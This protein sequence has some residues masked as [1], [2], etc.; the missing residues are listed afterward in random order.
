MYSSDS[1]MTQKVFFTNV[2]EAFW[3]GGRRDYSNSCLDFGGDPNHDVDTG[4]FTGIF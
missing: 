2:D 4:I 3:I 1:R